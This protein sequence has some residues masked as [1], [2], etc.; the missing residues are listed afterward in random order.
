MFRLSIA[1]LFVTILSAQGLEPVTLVLANRETLTGH[2]TGVDGD[3]AV[4]DVTMLGGNATIR[5]RLADFTQAS[6]FAILLAAA[7]PTTFDD[8]F[9]MAQ[10]AVRLGVMPQA[11]EQAGAARRLAECDPTGLQRK[12]L[13][14]WAGQTLGDLFQRAIAQND[15]VAARHHLRL[16][17]THVPGHFTA[18]QM[19]KMFDQ[20]ADT[21]LQ[22]RLAR[23]DAVAARDA[24][25]KR[26]EAERNWAPILKLLQQADE[27]VKS[28]LRNSRSTVQATRCFQQ[29]M[30]NYQAAW[31][32]LQAILKK[33]EKIPA[34]QEEGGSLILRVKE[35]AVQA[36][37]HAGNALAVQSDYR[38]AVDWANQ[39]LLIEPGN[40]DARELIRTI[41]VAQ[42]IGGAWGRGWVQ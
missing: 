3:W 26:P 30:G 22:Q 36:A 9:K 42:A 28:G 4:I 5:R 23:H 8:H 31:R 14:T 21:G 12:A 20:L 7:P 24:A 6:Q 37:L 19:G 10:A 39:A 29:A 15:L 32:D 25:A 17:A 41:Q 38:G 2:V 11:G 18:E 13:D 34:T 27:Q 16:I 40:A 35:S 33:D 1:A